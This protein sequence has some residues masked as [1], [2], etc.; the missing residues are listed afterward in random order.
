MP[1]RTERLLS[2]LRPVW[3]LEAFIAG[4]LGFLALDVYVA[5]SY[6][7]FAE[8]TEWVPVVAS[9]VAP[10]FLAAT[11]FGARPPHR[12]ASQWPAYL[13]GAAAIVVGVL[14]MVLHLESHFF[15]ERTLASL[16][17]A[18][19]FVAP[20]AYVGL[21]LLALMNR[22]VRSESWRWAQWVLLLAAGGYAGNFALAL[23]D[24]AQNGFFRPSE[25]LAVAA[26][27]FGTTFLVAAVVRPENRA[28]RRSTA[29]VLAV[30]GAI[31]LLGA[32]LHGLAVAS[33]SMPTL[34]ENVVYGA[35]PFAPLLF[36]DLSLLG[37]IGLWGAGRRAAA[38]VAAG[39]EGDPG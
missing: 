20:L 29:V 27:A 11:W 10:L 14:G 25:W 9:L 30:C 26:G 4:N 15:R 32:V 23:A 37:A 18:A 22:E 6:N 16:V 36:V 2:R 38:A 13:V 1:S 3:V 19:P 35:P 5:H 17:Y 8:P 31:G 24:H 28:L 21:G 33:G 7:E 12:H 34:W 39:A